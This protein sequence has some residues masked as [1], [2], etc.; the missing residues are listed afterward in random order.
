MSGCDKS[1][2]NLDNSDCVP[3]N[4]INAHTITVPGASLI[5]ESRF[6]DLRRDKRLNSNKVLTRR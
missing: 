5:L 6:V 1:N 3:L 4:T 2:L